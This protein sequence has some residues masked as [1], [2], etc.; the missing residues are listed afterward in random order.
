[1]NTNVRGEEESI[2]AGGSS[3]QDEVGEHFL[4]KRR[5]LVTEISSLVREDLENECGVSLF[6]F[7]AQSCSPWGKKDQKRLEAVA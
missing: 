5:A 7:T 1:M 6:P 2:F 3:C 4:G